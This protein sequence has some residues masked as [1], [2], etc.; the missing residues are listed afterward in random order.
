MTTKIELTVRD[1]Y[2]HLKDDIAEASIRCGRELSEIS[3]VLVAKYQPVQRL[4]QPL[5]PG[6]VI[7]QRII[8]KS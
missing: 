7:L 6:H 5:M 3:A 1:N 4:M 8:R 2:Q